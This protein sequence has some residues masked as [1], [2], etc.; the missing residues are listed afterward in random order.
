MRFDCIDA[1]SAN[2]LINLADG[3]PGGLEN[4]SAVERPRDLDG[5]VAFSDR[6]IYGGHVAG[7]DGR[8]AEIE[9]QDLR[10][11]YRNTAVEILSGKTDRNGSR[12]KM[13]QA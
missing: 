8:L 3:D 2:T 13:H 9:R 7:V 4:G 11:N 5:K 12:I 6:T 1:E 10:H